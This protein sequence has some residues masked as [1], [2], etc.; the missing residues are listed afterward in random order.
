MRAAGIG[1]EGSAHGRVQTEFEDN[2]VDDETDPGRGDAFG[3]VNG[4]FY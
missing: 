4:G 3:D 1:L 2:F